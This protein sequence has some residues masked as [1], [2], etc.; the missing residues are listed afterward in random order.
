MP[1]GACV[2]RAGIGIVGGFQIA[3]CLKSDAAIEPGRRQMAV[4]RFDDEIGLRD[5]VERAV[6]PDQ[7][8][9]SVQGQGRYVPEAAVFRVVK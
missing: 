4:A 7:S 5:R 1:A 3:E 8:T 6:K 9:G 2:K